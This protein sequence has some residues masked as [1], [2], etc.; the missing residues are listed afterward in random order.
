MMLLFTQRIRNLQGPN[1]ELKSN[2]E[3]HLKWILMS[4]ILNKDMRFYFSLLW[5]LKFV[6]LVINFCTRCRCNLEFDGR[7]LLFVTLLRFFFSDLKLLIFSFR[8]IE[9]CDNLV[10]KFSKYV[11]YYYF[12]LIYVFT[13]MNE[14]IIFRE[15]F[16]LY[17]F[18]WTSFLNK[19]LLWKTCNWML[20]NNKFRL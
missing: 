19:N 5:N 13:V 16:I 6:T 4:R 1:N 18:C 17:I 3:S 7:L 8:N 10:W 15:L 9:F 14:S 2:P 12:Y 11:K 20:T